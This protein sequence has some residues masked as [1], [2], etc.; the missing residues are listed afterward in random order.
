[1]A[2]EA[3]KHRPDAIFVDGGGVGGGVVDQLRAMKYRVVDVQSG[4][5]A[6][7]DQRFQNKRAEI[8]HNM[9][10]W[11]AVGCIPDDQELADDLLGPEYE[12]DS[13]GRT[14]L[15]SVEKMK[16]RGLASPDI[17]TALAMTFAQTVARRDNASRSRRTRVASDVDYSVLG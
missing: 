7:E 2:H 9:K 8:W 11:L 3:D 13:S 5:K 12:F 14:K 16:K 4:A 6:D 15:E 17:A 10:E 1:M